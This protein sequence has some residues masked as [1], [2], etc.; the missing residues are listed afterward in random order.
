MSIILHEFGKNVQIVAKLN[1]LSVASAVPIIWDRPE[2]WPSDTRDLSAGR[3][4]A[5]EVAS[6]LEMGLANIANDGVTI[7]KFATEYSRQ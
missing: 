3:R 5:F 6:L 1:G 2:T 4:T 7:P